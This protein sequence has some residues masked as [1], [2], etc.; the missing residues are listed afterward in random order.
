MATL[1]NTGMGITYDF[2]INNGKLHYRDFQY[3]S[4]EP[5]FN[6]EVSGDYSLAPYA[7]LNNNTLLFYDNKNYHFNILK[8]SYGQLKETKLDPVPLPEGTDTDALAFDPRMLVWNWS[9]RQKVGKKW[10]TMRGM[11]MGF[12]ESQVLRIWQI[13]IVSGLILAIA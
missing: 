12:L 1:Y 13:C 9:M 7:I 3:A 10:I 6:P 4:Y 8:C 11:P 2:I 5:L